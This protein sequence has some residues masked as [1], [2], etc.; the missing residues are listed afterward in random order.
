M[1]PLFLHWRLHSGKCLHYVAWP[2]RIQHF[3]F[4][5]RS[6]N[7]TWETFAANHQS[8]SGGL[9]ENMIHIQDGLTVKTNKKTAR[10]RVRKCG[11]VA[12]VI[13][14]GQR[15][16]K[17]QERKAMVAKVGDRDWLVHLEKGHGLGRD[18]IGKV[19]K[20][21]NRVWKERNYYLLLVIYFWELSPKK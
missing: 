21:L 6:T 2:E 1:Q 5:F 17:R 12:S 11:G 8:S 19:R 3:S 4:S 18:R 10:N 20:Q 14:S 9:K 16:S 7:A 13:H 15:I